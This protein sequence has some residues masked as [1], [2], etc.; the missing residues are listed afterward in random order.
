MLPPQAG[1]SSNWLSFEL[2]QD[3]DEL[4]SELRA[5]RCSIDQVGEVAGDPRPASMQMARE[6]ATLALLGAHRPAEDVAPLRQ[7]LGECPRQFL[8]RHGGEARTSVIENEAFM[9]RLLSRIEDS[10]PG[11]LVTDQGEMYL[12]GRLA[13]KV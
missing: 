3:S 6:L 9:R 7:D 2:P 1:V 13:G 8:I 12:S 11:I 5:Q 4:L 10:R